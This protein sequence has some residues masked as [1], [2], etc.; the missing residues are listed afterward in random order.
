MTYIVTAGYVTVPTAVPGGR[1]WVDI[2]RG[3]EV[4]GDVPDEDIQRLLSLGHIQERPEPEPVTKGKR[5]GGR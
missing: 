5:G 3:A 4:P 1:A 2:P